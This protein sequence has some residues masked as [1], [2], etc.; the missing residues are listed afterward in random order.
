MKRSKK[1]TESP[2]IL[3]IISDKAQS[4]IK[5]KED[6]FNQ[7]ETDNEV[8]D[9]PIILQNTENVSIGDTINN[10]ICDKNDLDCDREIVV[11]NRSSVEN[12]FF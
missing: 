10:K 4:L 9:I 2:I 3:K 1:Q 6:N 7:F 11:N 5:I 8:N 12:V